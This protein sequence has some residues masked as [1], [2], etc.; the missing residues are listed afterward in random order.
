M[1]LLI[2][3]VIPHMV[4]LF[5]KKRFRGLHLAGQEAI[6][7]SG[8]CS[9]RHVLCHSELPVWPISD[10]V[11]PVVPVTVTLWYLPAMS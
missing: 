6:W 3:L 4:D 1:D 11:E 9:A 5:L 7:C 10:L 2:S 8:S